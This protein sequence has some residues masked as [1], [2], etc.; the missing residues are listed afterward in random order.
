MVV[1]VVVVLQGTHGR[2]TGND[3]T[4][5]QTSG[6]ISNVYVVRHGMTLAPHLPSDGKWVCESV[7]E[8][9]VRMQ[10]TS[11]CPRLT[12][13]FF[14]IFFS[15]IILAY[16]LP[17]AA[18]FFTLAFQRCYAERYCAV[19]PP[20]V[21]HIN[22]PVGGGSLESSRVRLHGYGYLD[23]CIIRHPSIL[24]VYILLPGWSWPCAPRV[25]LPPPP[26]HGSSRLRRSAGTSR[27]GRAVLA[28][29]L[30]R[31]SYGDIRSGGWAR[32]AT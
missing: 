24:Y 7:R 27:S 4:T 29:E 28:M 32:R 13:L 18:Y 12:L 2:T 22:D 9:R 19:T 25:P 11:V 16:R 6:G 3:G 30:R 21:P 15:L 1:V 20:L 31:Q 10:C 8:C 17:L 26:P 14:I 23:D 5:A